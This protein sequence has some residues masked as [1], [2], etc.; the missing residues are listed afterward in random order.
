MVDTHKRLPLRKGGKTVIVEIKNIPVGFQ[1]TG[2]KT[3]R[4]KTWPGMQCQD[5]TLSQ[6]TEKEFS[7]ADGQV[8]HPAERVTCVS[9]VDSVKAITVCTSCRNDNVAT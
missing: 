9:C 4:S 6:K 3:S 8:L 7:R 2:H 5:Q 1:A